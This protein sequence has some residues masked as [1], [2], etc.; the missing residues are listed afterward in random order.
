[1]IT[2]E[3]IRAG[4]ALINAKQ[5]DLA[6]RAGISLATL[7]NIERSIAHPRRKTLAVIENALQAEGIEILNDSFGVGVRLKT[8]ERIGTTDS[9]AV[10][11]N[12]VHILKEKSIHP[13]ERCVLCLH[14]GKKPYF[15]VWLDYSI[16]HMIYDHCAFSVDNVDKAQDLAGLILAFKS[17]N[18]DIDVMIHSPNIQG[19]MAIDA[20]DQLLREETVPYEN[21]NSVLKHFPNSGDILRQTTNIPQ[22]L[23]NYL[24]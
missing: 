9:R 3:Q 15:Y 2:V 22:H 5:S 17:A 11:E 19:S 6:N 1:M 14:A 4:R 7:N 8:H 10:L 13:I 23:L 18:V 16:R 24:L 12:I 21:I 20:I